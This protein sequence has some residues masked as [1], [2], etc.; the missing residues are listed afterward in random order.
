M[1]PGPPRF[2]DNGSSPPMCMPGGGRPAWSTVSQEGGCHQY[3]GHGPAFLG[4]F[5]TRARVPV[6]PGNWRIGTG[7]Q[8]RSRKP[9]MC[10]ARPLIGPN[11]LPPLSL[12]NPARPFDQGCPFRRPDFIEPERSLSKNGNLSGQAVGG[13]FS[14]VPGRDRTQDGGPGE[15]GRP[16]PVSGADF[17]WRG[18]SRGSRA[19]RHH[20]RRSFRRFFRSDVFPGD[21]V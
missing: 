21:F 16:S 18:S 3:G 9:G 2:P 20:G 13:I 10:E 5:R 11:L 12:R 7:R 1:S 17:P 8:L 4:G 14:W 15:S 19:G 6:V